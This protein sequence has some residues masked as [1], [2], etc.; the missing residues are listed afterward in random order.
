MK[1]NC[2]ADT[3][4]GLNKDNIED[5]YFMDP[6]NGL[7]LICD[8]MGGH[9]NGEI[10]SR[11]A[12]EA[13]ILYWKSQ[14]ASNEFKNSTEIEKDGNKLF[15]ELM[16]ESYITQSTSIGLKYRYLDEDDFQ[17]SSYG[18]NLSFHF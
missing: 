17:I 3:D 11:T 14:T 16:L 13:V 4:S 15:Y 1:I 2:H 7:F 9:E 8:G 5:A 12:I 6:E 10:A 18:M